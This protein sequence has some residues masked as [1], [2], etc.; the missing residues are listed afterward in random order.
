M[1]HYDTTTHGVALGTWQQTGRR[2]TLWDLTISAGGTLIGEGHC[3]R[4]RTPPH[5]GKTRQGKA[6][7]QMWVTVKRNLMNCIHKKEK[8]YENQNNKPGG[9][10]WNNRKST[11]KS[12]Q[13]KGPQLQYL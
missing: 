4:H 2:G 13:C 5:Y 8:K 11:K 6:H 1:A 12:E 10:L 9:S 3:F 7:T